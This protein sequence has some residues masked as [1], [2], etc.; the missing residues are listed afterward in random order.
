MNLLK[1]PEHGTKY[2]IYIGKVVYEPYTREELLK[3]ADLEV[4]LLELHLFDKEKEYRYIKKR[5]GY[6]ET[7]I[8]DETVELDDK[9]DKY[10]ETIFTLKKNQEKPDENHGEVRVINYIKYDENDLLTIQDYRLVEV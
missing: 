6:I 2:A 10:E 1:A 9:D 7:E 4:N 8:S 5:K 3:D